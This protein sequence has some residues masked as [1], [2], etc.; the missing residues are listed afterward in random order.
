MP[1]NRWLFFW[2][3]KK[4]PCLHFFCLSWRIISLP[5]DSNVLSLDPHWKTYLHETKHHQTL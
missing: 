5:K 3:S 1:T 2:F 4:S